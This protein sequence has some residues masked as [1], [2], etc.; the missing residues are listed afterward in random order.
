MDIK[1]SIFL[2]VIG[3]GLLLTTNYFQPFNLNERRESNKEQESLSLSS[4]LNNSIW[5]FADKDMQLSFFDKN[6]KKYAK[7]KNLSTG[8]ELP[9]E[10]KLLFDKDLVI[11]VYKN[12]SESFDILLQ[13]IIPFRDK[14]YATLKGKTAILQRVT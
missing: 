11:T 10:Y 4:L 14:M 12:L 3:F 5:K 7:L 6:G 8:A 9:A 2:P 1:H 13:D